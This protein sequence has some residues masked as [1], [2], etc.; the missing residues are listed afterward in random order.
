M[1]T[2]IAR[3]TTVKDV[4]AT[5]MALRAATQGQGGTHPDSDP[6]LFR[7]LHREAE[8]ITDEVRWKKPKKRRKFDSARIYLERGEHGSF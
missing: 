4:L 3:P 1:D 7:P 6:Q 8:L 5:R 2:V